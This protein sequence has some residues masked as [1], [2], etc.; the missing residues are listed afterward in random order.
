MDIQDMEDDHIRL[1]G[2]VVAG[3]GPQGLT[4]VLPIVVLP[5]ARQR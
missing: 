3:V 2:S 1:Q 5:A 4:V